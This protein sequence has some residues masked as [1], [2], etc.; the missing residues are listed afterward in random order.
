MGSH[1]SKLVLSQDGS[2]PARDD[3]GAEASRAPEHKQVLP[4][5]HHPEAQQAFEWLI[6]LELIW[7]HPGTSQ[8]PEST[9]SHCTLM[10]PPS[11]LL[12]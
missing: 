6:L 9:T 4:G 7:I 8:K 10:Y 1:W 3:G 2:G 12:E 5:A 11:C